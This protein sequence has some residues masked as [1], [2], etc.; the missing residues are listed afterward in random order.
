MDGT[1]FVVPVRSIHARANPKYFGRLKG[2]TL[3]NMVNDQG[4]G[5]AGMVLSGTPRDS[6]HAV[7]LFY[8]RDGGPPSRGPYLRQAL[9]A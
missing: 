7:D 4:V 3:L 6:L 2:A 5:V 9:D 1:R 8:R